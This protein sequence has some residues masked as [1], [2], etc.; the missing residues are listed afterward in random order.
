MFRTNG[1]YYKTL[2]NKVADWKSYELSD[3]HGVLWYTAFYRTASKSFGMAH[4]GET[5]IVKNG[6]D[7]AKIDV[8]KEDVV[9]TSDRYFNKLA[10][11]PKEFAIIKETINKQ[12]DNAWLS[13]RI[14]TIE[15]L[16]NLVSGKKIE[17]LTN[18]KKT[19]EILTLDSKFVF[20]LMWE[21]TNESLGLELLNLT[22]CKQEEKPKETIDAGKSRTGAITPGKKP[23]AYKIGWASG[24]YNNEYDIQTRQRD[25][26][27]GGAI[28][29]MF[30]GK[31]PT[32]GANPDWTNPPGDWVNPDGQN[33]WWD[34]G[35]PDG[36]NPWDWWG[37]PD[38]QNGGG[39]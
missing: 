25:L 16:K 39:G 8:K 38:G 9:K 21:C 33:P 27:I 24:I 6:D 35:N 14:Q 5:K 19:K 18:N 1:E 11:N 17:K 2:A 20:Y 30:K 32:D 15:D 23:S 28:K 37:N 31:T 12:I 13:Y 3:A 4:P 7:L 10:A 34:G 36:Q 29:W 26:T 22:V